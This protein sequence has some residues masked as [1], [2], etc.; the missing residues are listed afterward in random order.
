MRKTLI[1]I[2]VIAF[3][4]PP[5]VA[6]EKQ[7]SAGACLNFLKTANPLIYPPAECDEVIR[8]KLEYERLC[9]QAT[10]RYGRPLMKRLY[11]KCLALLG[12]TPPQAS[13]D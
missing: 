9:S 8:Q 6:Q 1:A 3:L 2:A 7:M 12:L 11:P 10:A 5:A 4:A 13:S